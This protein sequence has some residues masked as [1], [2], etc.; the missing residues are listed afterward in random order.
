MKRRFPFCATAAALLLA[1][2]SVATQAQEADDGSTRILDKT[3]AT[4]N[5]RLRRGDPGA[6]IQPFRTVAET[7][8]ELPEPN[9]ALALAMTLADFSTRDDALPHVRRALAY[10]PAN[11]VAGIVA[12]IVDPALSQLRPDGQLYLTPLAVRRLESAVSL[13]DHDFPGLRHR[14]HLLASFAFTAEPTGDVF[15]PMRLPNVGQALGPGGRIRLPGVGEVVAFGAMFVV[16]IPA[17]RFASYDQRV[18]ERMRDAVAALEKGQKRLETIRARLVDVRADAV[19]LDARLGRIEAMERTLAEI[20]TSADEREKRLLVLE[21][22]RPRP[23]PELPNHIRRERAWV[24]ELRRV[25]ANLR[26]RLTGLRGL[27]G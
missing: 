13:L 22:N 5:E 4:G 2:A 27:G 23:D 7:I 9:A 8:P 19:S 6:A 17:P 15:Y 20:E 12:V 14:R 16:D 1:T 26:E 18:V 21:L 10:E 24:E 11:P 3:Y 25:G